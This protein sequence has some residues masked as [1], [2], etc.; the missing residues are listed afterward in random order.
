MLAK[1]AKIKNSYGIGI[2]M[3][4]TGKFNSIVELEGITPSS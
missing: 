2:T 1:R 3:A 4:D